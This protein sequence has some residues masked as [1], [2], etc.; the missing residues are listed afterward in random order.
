MDVKAVIQRV[1]NRLG[2]E[3]R[4]IGSPAQ[5]TPNSILPVTHWDGMANRPPDEVEAYRVRV[6]EYGETVGWFH[7]FDF[8]N[9]V[10]AHGVASPAALAKRTASLG[11]DGL[12]NKTFLDIASWDGFYAFEAERRGARRVLAVDKFCWGGDGWGSKAGFDLVH[13]ILRSRIE[14]QTIEADDLSPE[15][16]GMW[17]VVLFSGI[18]YHLRDPLGALA[19]AASV[20]SERMIVETHVYNEQ[21]TAPLMQYVPRDPKNPKNSGSNYWR[22]NSAMILQLLK[23]AGFP[24]VEYRIETD[25][26]G[27]PDSMHGFFT[28]HR[29]KDK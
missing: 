24:R 27:G 9:G 19:A 1:A 21:H 20:C 22:P 8:G 17:D 25:P 15:T 11:L 18:F 10:R 29:C 12:I 2:Y 6:A 23:E 13:E 7:S 3:I 16:V 5:P 14:S 28:A 4:K 26:P